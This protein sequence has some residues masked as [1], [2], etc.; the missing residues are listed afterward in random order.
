M[1]LFWN[2]LRI[3]RTPPPQKKRK[4]TRYIFCPGWDNLY[5]VFESPQNSESNQDEKHRTAERN[6]MYSQAYVANRAQVSWGWNID[7]PLKF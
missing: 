5:G 7:P 2:G 1:P 3:K 6:H 4:K